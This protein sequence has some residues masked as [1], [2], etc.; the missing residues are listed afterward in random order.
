MGSF[1]PRR[2][3][4]TPGQHDE[5][6]HYKIVNNDYILFD[7]SDDVF[8]D[9]PGTGFSRSMGRNKEMAFWGVDPDAHARSSPAFSPSEI[10]GIRRN[11]SLA[12]ATER[13]AA[14]YSPL[15]C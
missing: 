13:R 15:L 14:L 5:G 8:I 6:A 7:V 11:T 12:K 2:V 3:V 1:G 4:T 10:A 9:E